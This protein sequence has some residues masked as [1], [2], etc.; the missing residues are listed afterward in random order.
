MRRPAGPLEVKPEQKLVS[1]Y[2]N[3]DYGAG[4]VRGVYT[5]G[6]AAIAP[7]FVQ[8]IAPL[9]DL[10][11]TTITN[12]SA[13]GTDHLSFDAVGIPGFQFIQD[14]LDYGARTHHSNEDVY[15]RLQPADLKQIATVEA[16]FVY[17]AAQRDQ[18]LPRKPLPQPDLEEKKRA[19]IEGIFPGA[20]APVAAEK[21]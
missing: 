20:V 4:K 8:W 3:V 14:E 5:Q 7:I 12:R 15:E 2:F 13:G 6:N 21:K 17:N 19:P 18:M 9:R 1:A 11:V 16:I 10:G